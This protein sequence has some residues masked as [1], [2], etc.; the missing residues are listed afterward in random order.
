MS[1]FIVVFACGV[2][3]GAVVLGVPSVLLGEEEDSHAKFGRD[4]PQTPEAQAE[5]MKKWQAASTP[6]KAHERISSLTGRNGST[7]R[8]RRPRNARLEPRR[9]PTS[10]KGMTFSGPRA[11][12]S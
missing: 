1:R 2:L 3:L 11:K 9:T 5:M 6:G 7:G 8:S 4:I 10:R 12:Q